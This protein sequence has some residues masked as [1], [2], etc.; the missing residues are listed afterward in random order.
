MV[1]SRIAQRMTS[2]AAA[3]L[4]VIGMVTVGIA[5]APTA[6]AAGTVLFNQP[7]HDNTVDG[8]VG[9][10]SLPAP[11]AGGSNFAC[12]TAAGNATKNPLASCA[13]P[14]DTQG[15]GTLRFTQAVTGEEGG[16]FASTSV[17]TSQG[18]DVT[19]NSY[20]Y[21]GTGAD[22]LAFVLAA[23]NP[24]NPVIPSVMGQ[25]G[26]ALGYSAENSSTNGLS[27]GY[28]G[29]GFD[30]Y[31]NFSNKYEGS[32]CTDPANIAQ[33]MPGQVVV[34][35]PGNLAVGYCALQSSAATASSPSLTLRAL[36]RTGSLVPVEVVFNPTS[37]TVTTASGLVVPAGDYDVTFT[38]VG[39]TARS[40][41]GALPVVPSGLYPASWVSSS[42]IPKQL[43]FGWVAS[44]GS[45]TDYHEINNVVVSS[46]N[47]VPVLAVSQTSYAAST[48]AVGSPVTYTVAASSSGAAE[49]QP[50]TVIET[51]PVGV[52]PVGAS[53]TGWVC[54]APSGQQISCTSSTS[55]FTSGTITVNGVVTS[56]SVTP[57]LVQS[58]TTVV[59]SSAD[60]SPATSSSAPAGTVP[61][62]PGITAISPTNGAAG[63][64]ND[65]KITGTGLGA[66]TAVEIGTAADFAAGTPTTVNLCAASGP[67]CF[68]VVSSTSLDISAMPAH[69]AAA[70]TVKVVTLGTSASTTYTYNAGPALLFPAPPG[71]EVGVTYSD[72]LAVTGGTSPFT[73]SVSSGSLPPGV[74]LGASTGLLSGTPT[75]A[76]SYSFTV[77]VTDSSGLSST[78]AATVTII[79]G[80]SMTFAAPPGGWTNTVYGYT[81]TESGGTSPFTWSVSSGSLPAGISLSPDG[82][83]SGTPTATG[84]S[85]FTVQVTDANGRTAAQAT[86]ITVSAGVS[87]TFAAP[88]AAA[89]NSAYSYTLTATGGTTPYTWS[90]NA[91]TLPAG[92]T[93]SSVGVLSGTP[94]TT[95]SYPFSVNVIDANKGIA[96]ASITLVVTAALTLTFP[97]PPSGTIGTAYTDTFTAAGG[98]TPYTFSISAGTLPAGLTLNASTGVVS[99][100]PTTAGTSSFTVKVTDA[101]SATATFA[102]SIT[103]LSSVLTL[104]LTSSAATAAPG[105]TVSYTITA[106]NSGQVAL[107][108]ATFTDALSDVL[109]DASYNGNASATAGS[110][111]FASPNLTWIGTLAVGAA[112]TITFSVT[113][114]NPDTGNKSLVSTITSTTSSSNCASGSTD[115][116][117]SSTVGVSIL[118]IAMTASTAS[119]TPGSVVGYTITVTNS[120][121]VAYTGATL[122]D[123]LSGVLDDGAYNGDATATAGSLSYT[124]PNLTWTGNLAVGASATITFSVTVNNPDTGNKILASTITSATA[125][126]NC[127]S[128]SSDARCASSV[129]VLVPALTI[130]NSAGV[131]SATPGSVVHFM[132]TITNTGQTAYTAITVTDSLSGLVDDAAYN[133]DAT[134]TAGTLAYASPVLTWTGTLAVGAAATVTFSVTVNAT[135]TG[136][137][138]L[139]TTVSTAAAGSDCAAGSTDARCSTAVPVLIPGLDLTVTANTASATP[140]SVVSYTVVADNTGQTTDTGVS[141]AA[142]L[143]GLLD[144][145]AY[146]GNAAATSGLVSYTSPNLTWTGTLAAGAVATVT[147]SATV[148]TP[149]TGNH[150]V[151]V[152]LTST[153]AGNNCAAG[154]T[155]PSCAVSVPV[156]S[157]AI[158]NSSNVAST[159]PGGVVRFTATFTNTGQVPYTGITISTNAADVFD[160]AVPDGDQTATSGTLT[161]TGAAVVWTGSIPVGGAVTLTGTVTV[162]NPDTGNH[163]LAS[164]ITTAAAG[165][166]C[167]ATAPAAACSISVPVLTPGLTITNTPNTTATTPGATVSYTLAITDSGQTPYTGITVTEDLSG[168][169]DD[170]V[171]NNNAAA[172][173]GTV[174]YTS[175]TVTWTGSLAAG[176]T[177]TV[178]FSVTVNNPD[179]GDKLLI[180]TGTS[181]AAGSACLAGT[182]ATPCRS[183]VAVLTP[184]L[185]IVATAGTATAVPGATVHY[186][187]VITNTGQTPYAGISVTDSLSGLLDDA[188]YNGDAAAS[189]GSV[190]FTSPNLTWTGSLAPGAAATVTF[191]VTVNNPDTGD[192]SLTT[193]ITSTASGNNCTAGSTDPSCATSVPV[194]NAALLTMGVSSAAASAVA[195]GVVQYTVT[196]TNAAATPYS[197]A[198]FTDSL[199]G[200]L[201]N[202]T[203]NGDA[204]ASTGTVTYTSPTLTWTGTVPANGTA[205][206]T[207]S[208]TVSNPD[209]G[210]KILTNVLTSA[211]TGG[212]CPAGSTDPACASTVTVSSLAITNTSNVT[213]TTPGSVVRFTATFTNTGQTPYDG[214]VISTNAADVFDDAVPDGDQTATSGTLTVTGNGVAWAGDIP[215]GG[216]VTVTGTVTVNNPDT[217]NHVLASTITTAAAGSNCPTAAPAAACSVSIPVLTPALTITNT[218]NTTATTPGSTVSYTV[219]ITDS[220]QTPYTGITVSDDLAGILDD[221]VYDGDAAAT[222]GTVSYT[223]PTLT[224]TGSL[225]PGAAATVTFTVTV[226]NPDTG[227]KLLITTATSTAPGSACPVGTTTAPCR[228]TVLVLTPAL[229]IAATTSTATA[230]AGGTEHYT[231]TITDTGQTPYTAITVTDNL[232]G[233]L[234]DA[235]YNND[236]AATAGTVS[237]TTP[238]VTWTGSLT[239]GTAATVT[240][241]VT[242]NNPDTGNKTLTTLITSAA[243][244]NNCRA[245]STD[246]NCATSVPVAMFTMTNTASTSTTTPGSV[247]TYTV[248]ITNTGQVENFDTTATLP[249]SGV[250]DDAAYNGDAAATSGV[251]TYT[252]PNLTWTGDLSPGQSATTTFSV[253]VNNPDTGTKTLTDT[254]TSTTPGAS[255]PAS[256]P[257]PAACTT[258]VT[259]LIPALT[260]TKT[261]NAA[262]T[263]PGS[264]VQYTITVADTGQT[265][266]TAATVTDDLSNVLSDAAYDADAAATAGTVTYTSP[267]LTW[268]GNLTPGGTAIITFS[269]TVDNPDTGDKILTNTV[270]STAAGSTC[271]P[272]GP[273]PAC[274]T[275][276]TDLIPALTIT[277]TAS[278]TATTPGST[279]HYTITVADTGQTPYTAAVLTDNLSGVLGNAAYNNDA[280]ATTGTVTYASPTLTWT[281]NLTPGG[282]AT[283]TY[284]VTVNNPD[285]GNG[286]LSN[287]VVST[288]TGS[289][290]PAGSG[291]PGCNVT[292]AVVAGPLSITVPAT[293]SL[294]SA[295]PGG[296]LSAGLGTVQVTDDR[297][298]GAGWTATVSATGFATGTGTPAETIPAADAQYLISALTTTTGSATFTPVPAIQLGASP[299]PVVN[300]TNVAGN[301]TVTW[302]P[303]IQ[304]AVPAGAIGGTYTATITHSVS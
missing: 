81:L 96:T 55:P 214:I 31:G 132:V 295:A 259:V 123:S 21:G 175:P 228:S 18:L 202:A 207:Y 290:C 238:T 280:A 155:D 265:P 10:V 193:V 147:F 9:S 271:P 260:I 258:T 133:N 216:T 151:A 274:S 227:G 121:P 247:V 43:V 27:Y 176:A 142:S 241:S 209:T 122:T 37:S 6:S 294:G 69:T 221:A 182:T 79:P 275:T 256:G 134:A 129:T 131:S 166:N 58:S 118:T 5:S 61:A 281:G 246:P 200:V 177:A 92:I 94:T 233:L 46:I 150:L 218:P 213:S 117:C 231:I 33:R 158:T 156:A 171:Y 153:A 100:T 59:A 99:G 186:T 65:V 292:V 83:L 170:A 124:S 82:N 8:P 196:V 113:V 128:G 254:L 300:A 104:A 32:G 257:A 114:N 178:T 224:W 217:G 272:S 285:T 270:T 74:T 252:S 225:A 42:G 301:T 63:G 75:T 73:W 98:T 29:V 206:I 105:G 180:V 26:G 140:G 148:N 237:Y 70:V 174:S 17:P 1:F 102:T 169:S 160:D 149:D 188:A 87:T 141:F 126:S 266:Y 268:A 107:T 24:A 215:V 35:G 279:V 45:V 110:V 234:D 183:T 125:G 51:L 263:T 88:P 289:T 130:V 220:G 15:S 143:S 242:V 261:A 136:D 203:Y 84:T 282:T 212:N 38:P 223:S 277:K 77:K 161:I 146:N 56:S 302:D 262:T 40:L 195:G 162:T 205:T 16:V 168:I 283:I 296:T 240:F 211:S 80:P 67:G 239:P 163:V 49:N 66:A 179:T 36:T 135:D 34:R 127:A 288:A 97:S 198:T 106:T 11:G 108:G 303:T 192:R 64:A 52:L 39:G 71:G 269:V 159:T 145:A 299:Q 184:G 249:L 173:A 185:D 204:A 139:G 222:T 236:A 111:S 190:S 44:T 76:G 41:V 95:G 152:T 50:V 13:A 208:V 276:V 293:A 72:Q 144:D 12:L 137:K 278:T 286:A 3:V 194:E 68:T 210:N 165:S 164:T 232:T 103:I 19:F 273:A 264:V 4:L 248:T 115:A 154:S 197:G 267:V 172:T 189:T 86:S 284:S 78:E 120:G 101:K 54:G 287:T 157:L 243:A 53:G 219:A 25:S 187:V 298:F 47:P 93:L 291:S 20:Q 62:A 23:V 191:T 28:L 60:A 251:V 7:F 85:S 244:R 201:A 230:V 255:C 199:S 90:V 304:V 226:H 297:G 235:A 91:G 250:L 57:A 14:N 181:A 229:T 253:T 2:P 167:P 109:D 112:A 48:L 245:G 116:R 138:V 22:G 89:V 30:A 119:T